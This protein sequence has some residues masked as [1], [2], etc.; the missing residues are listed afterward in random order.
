MFMDSLLYI[1]CFC[2]HVIKISVCRLWM[3]VQS[4]LMAIQSLLMYIQ[5]L[6]TEI[7]DGLFGKDCSLLW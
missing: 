7:S 6:Q 4:L 3:A 1:R 2:D 5:R